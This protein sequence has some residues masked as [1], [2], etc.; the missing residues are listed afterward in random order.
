MFPQSFRA[1]VG[2]RMAIWGAMLGFLLALYATTEFIHAQQMA[3]IADARQRA[4]I[5]VSAFVETGGAV[6]RIVGAARA[7][8]TRDA[9]VADINE[10]EAALKPMSDHG[11][12]DRLTLLARETWARLDEL[13]ASIMGN[14]KGPQLDQA[15]AAAIAK[16]AELGKAT[17]EVLQA[18]NERQN[19]IFESHS[20]NKLLIT[21]L[22]LFVVA[23]ILILEHRWLIEPIVRMAA[24]LRSGETAWC[25]LAA[26][27][28]RRDEIG[29][30]AQ[31]LT[32]HVQLVRQ[33]QEAAHEEQARLSERL[34]RQGELKRASMAFQDRIAGIVNGLEGHAVRMAAAS[35]NLVSISSEADAR[36]GASAQSTQR[37]SDHVDLVASS[38]RDIA[39]TFT[40][41]VDEAEKTSSVAA[42]ARH[43]VE[44][45]R[46]DAKA[47]M[48]A[49]RA[50]EPVIA[51]IEHV[52]N[53]TNLLALNATIE[54]ARAGEMGRGFA[55]VAHEVKQLATRTSRA[56]E[57]VRSGLHGMTAASGRIAERVTNL[58]QSI[59]QVDGVAAAI[60][61]SMRS[62][63]ATSQAI[64]SNSAKTAGD[65]RDVAAAVKDVAEMITEARRAAD[66]VTTSSADLGQQAA[67][68]RSAVDGFIEKTEGIAA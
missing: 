36:A 59:E 57:D 66:L 51:L 5:A 63:D 32:G 58:V 61:A 4:T 33:Q 8:G 44:A 49:A 43:L 37:V 35:K 12:N 19:A 50:I 40:A 3:D 22:T 7:S 23:Q 31:A 46:D 28:P 11:L 9:I 27:V 34:S 10:M 25:D 65:V 42:A 29:V 24:V 13:K 60:A 26:Y 17:G 39:G 53:Q 54:A 21:L 48:E 67:D 55:V 15:L 56:T 64:T 52:A 16:R 14:A 30:F 2:Q 6:G 1:R 20:Q 45:A 38:I 68:L 18:I 41:V 62:Q 47:L